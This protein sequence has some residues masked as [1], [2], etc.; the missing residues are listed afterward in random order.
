MHKSNATVPVF[1][2]ILTLALAAAPD[3]SARAATSAG[4]YTWQTNL[5]F[6]AFGLSSTYDVDATGIDPGKPVGLVMHFHGDGAY[7]YLHPND[8]Y[9]L[10]GPE[11]IRAVARAYNM[12]TVSAL[13]PD[14]ATGN[15]TWWWAGA[16]YANYVYALIDYIYNEYPIDHSRVWLTGYSGG[17]QFISQYYLPAYAG[18]GQ[19]ANGGAAMFGGGEDPLAASP[20]AAVIN[21]IPAGFK[22]NFHMYWGAGTADGPDGTGWIGG[23]L[24][25][26]HGIAWYQ[27]QGFTQIASYFPVGW[28]HATTDT[29]ESFEWQFGHYLHEQLDEIFQSGFDR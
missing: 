12:I 26:Q 19:I 17:A 2:G 25:A 7:G 27:G 1:S 14:R 5:P 15:L 8:S 23:Y 3:P 21:P 9:A 24:S 16:D 6:S 28:C 29:C 13:T 10:G 11:G 20:Q 18:S 22:R 4:P